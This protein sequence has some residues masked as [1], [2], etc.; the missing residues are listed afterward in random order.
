MP[1]RLKPALCK[2][3]RGGLPSRAECASSCLPQ[4]GI[5]DGLGP[6]A[7]VEGPR[8]G[9]GPES[10]FIW[11]ELRWLMAV[12]CQCFQ[13]LERQPVDLGH[14][15]VDEG[16]SWINQDSAARCRGPGLW[17][18]DPSDQSF[19]FPPFL[20]PSLPPSAQIP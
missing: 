8:K 20:P 10:R 3:A 1:G 5:R 13:K 18:W 11:G 6:A 17:T 15:G 4:P 16:D 19:S 7:R 12:C 2:A 9:K 14:K